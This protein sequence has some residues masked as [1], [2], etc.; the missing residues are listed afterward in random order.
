[1]TSLG[2]LQFNTNEYNEYLNKV[3]AA[4]TN[5]GIEVIRFT[6]FNYHEKL[7]K[8]DGMK[9]DKVQQQWKDGRFPLPEYI[10]DRTFFP[11]NKLFR[12]AMIKKINTI[13]KKTIFLGSGLPNKWI[14]YQW[15]QQNNTLKKHLPPTTLLSKASLQSYL[16]TFS[17]IVLKPIFGSGG[18]GFYVV[19]MTPDHYLI[20]NGVNTAEHRVDKDIHE[21][22]EYIYRKLISEG[23]L[24]QPYLPLK[25]NNS[26]FDLRIVVQ[27]NSV[28]KWKVVGKGFRIG[29]K[30][31]FLSNLQTGGEIRSSIPIS[32]K[33][34]EYLK[35]NIA[36]IIRLIPNQLER[37]HQPLFELGIDIGISED[38]RL[39]IL[40][41]NSKPGYQTV[42]RTI[43]KEKYDSIFN[44]PIELVESLEKKRREQNV[45]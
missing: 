40:E 24:I 18:Y 34:A 6:P 3:A 7:E 5:K 14:V 8:I 29:K 4:S 45:L 11:K 9:Y 22:Y 38:G 35:E 25:V 12:K 13:K 27:R 37:F 17:K 36:T 1:M 28:S 39:W 42:M 10:Y 41:V 31:T 44:G 26:P 19:E 30:G 21:L 23:Y 2:I 16:E 20:S 33:K 32:K 15:L 43:M